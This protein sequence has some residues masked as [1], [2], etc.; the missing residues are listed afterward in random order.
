MVNTHNEKALKTSDSVCAIDSNWPS[1]SAHPL[2]AI[3]KPTHRI[4]PIN[5]SWAIAARGASVA[6]AVKTRTNTRAI[7]GIHGRLLSMSVP[8]VDALGAAIT[9]PPVDK[10]PW[11]FAREPTQRTHQP[12]ELSATATRELGLLRSHAQVSDGHMFAALRI[13][14]ESRCVSRMRRRPAAQENGESSEITT[15]CEGAMRRER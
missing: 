4:S 9:T 15:C 13:Q 12:P 14:R 6:P 11:P 5:S 7:A 2:G 8:L 10:S 3:L 1:H